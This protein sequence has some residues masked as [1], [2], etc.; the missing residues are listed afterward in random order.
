MMGFALEMVCHIQGLKN[1]SVPS[2]IFRF[3]DTESVIITVAFSQN[4][5]VERGCSSTLIDAA[6]LLYASTIKQMIC[7]GSSFGKNIGLSGN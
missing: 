5:W 3:F 1:F 4:I 6:N 7:A 2:L